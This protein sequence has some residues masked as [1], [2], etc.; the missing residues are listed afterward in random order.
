MKPL[1]ISI[2]PLMGFS[3]SITTHVSWQDARCYQ[4]LTLEQQTLKD[5]CYFCARMCLPDN[6][7]C[8]CYDKYLYVRVSIWSEIQDAHPALFSV[9]WSNVLA[10]PKHDQEM[11]HAASLVCHSSFSSL[12]FSSSVSFRRMKTKIQHTEPD[13]NRELCSAY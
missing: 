6:N 9:K 4:G 10:A 5:R 8:V 3:R 11:S 12:A 2:T 13:S 7:I 1:E